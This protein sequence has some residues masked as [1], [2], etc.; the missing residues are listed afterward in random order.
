MNYFIFK[1]ELCKGFSIRPAIHFCS[2]CGY[3]SLTLF[4]MDVSLIFYLRD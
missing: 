4:N 3:I 1:V 2:D